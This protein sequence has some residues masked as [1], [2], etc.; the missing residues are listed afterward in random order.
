MEIFNTMESLDLL[1]KK[2]TNGENEFF[3]VKNINKG[4]NGIIIRKIKIILHFTL[5]QILFTNCTE[6]RETYL[7]GGYKLITSASMNDLIIVDKNQI[8]A[9]DGHILEYVFDSIFIL[10]AQR[11]RDSVLECT[12]QGITFE[13][14]QE[15][16]KRSTFRQYWIINKE[17]KSK[18]FYDTVKKIAIYSNVYGPF[19]KEKY[20]QKCEELRVPKELKLKE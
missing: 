8:V 13:K 20:I 15:A 16:F 4:L 2:K 3:L 9:I 5:L 11:P 6:N 19:K 14:S 18:Y 10:A 12:I 1:L 17:E 7:G